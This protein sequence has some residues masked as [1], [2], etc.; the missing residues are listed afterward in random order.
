MELPVG[1]DVYVCGYYGDGSYGSSAPGLQ[2]AI[3]KRANG[4]LSHGYSFELAKAIAV[5]GQD[6]YIAG[7][8]LKDLSSNN[9]RVAEIWKNGVRSQISRFRLG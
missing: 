9:F 3:G 8:G 4:D 6:V 1:K 7:Y 5:K 2:A